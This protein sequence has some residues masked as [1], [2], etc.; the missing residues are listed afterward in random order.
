MDD[1]HG[2]EHLLD[3]PV[4]PQS[5]ENRGGE[6]RHPRPGARPFREDGEHPVG[7]KDE[8]PVFQEGSRWEEE[9]NDQQRENEGGF[10]ELGRLE[11]VARK[12][13]LLLI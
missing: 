10:A 1:P 9:A 2:N 5:E 7:E 11:G 3:L 4:Y 13:H 8:G 12:N 6:S